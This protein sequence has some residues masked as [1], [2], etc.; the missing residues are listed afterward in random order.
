M[1]MRPMTFAGKTGIPD[2]FAP[3][4]SDDQPASAEAFD[5]NFI[6]GM[7]VQRRGPAYTAVM[8]A[9]QMHG[10]G[11]NC[12]IFG[13]PNLW[14][15]DVG[16][17]VFSRRKFPGEQYVARMPWA[18]AYG[19][20]HKVAFRKLMQHLDRVG[21]DRQL[22]YTWG[23][24]SLE[25]ARALHKRGVP[26][27]REKI[28]CAKAAAREI[29]TAAY[30]GLG[31]TPARIITDAQLAKEAEE[32]ELA[33]AIFCPSPMVRRTLLQAGVPESKLIST[34]YGWEPS[35]FAGTDRALPEVDVP[36]F[37]F[38]GMVCVR[39]GA[40]I[41]LEAWQRAGC[42]GRLVLVG[43]MEPII[44]RRFKA[45][46]THETV[47]YMSYTRNIAAIFRSADWFVFPTLEEGGPQVTYEA[48]GCG[49][50][51]IVS[52][53]GAGAFT[54]HGQDGE[55][56]GSSSVEAWAD[57]LRRLGNARELQRYYAENARRNADTYVWE[58]VGRRRREALLAR[59]AGQADL[60]S[61]A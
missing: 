36:T 43:E 51:G 41:L 9:T 32:M 10:H 30:A 6:L 54:R 42:P 47:Q 57:A 56:V 4:L 60:H 17:R 7:P 28:N 11:L 59:L 61:Q 49:V 58:A 48:A 55:I 8:L 5:L 31:E 21:T 35:R 15:G 53:M 40:H 45:I 52:E 22:V 34:S 14:P 24:T 26:V 33:D 39:K 2:P 29:L 20:L 44:A 13:H 1:D 16:V 27:V 23:E 38:V 50:P 25:M 46:L 19:F 37:L 18:S 3:F 12:Q